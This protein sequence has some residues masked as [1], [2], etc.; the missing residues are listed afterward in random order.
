[1][2]IIF[3]VINSFFENVGVLIGRTTRNGVTGIPF[4]APTTGTHLGSE[5]HIGESKYEY[6]IDAGTT[7]SL[8][9]S[10]VNSTMTPVIVTSTEATSTSNYTQPFMSKDE[11][12]MLSNQ[13]ISGTESIDLTTMNEEKI[14]AELDN[15]EN[16][17]KKEDKFEENENEWKSTETYIEYE[18]STLNG[19]DEFTTQTA[20][21][22]LSQNS[23]SKLRFNETLIDLLKF[24]LSPL[25]QRRP[26][27]E[28]ILHDFNDKHPHFLRTI[29]SEITNGTASTETLLI[30]PYTEFLSLN[31]TLA[32]S[33][34]MVTEPYEWIDTLFKPSEAEQNDSS[35][36]FSE[37]NVQQ[38]KIQPRSDEE[39]L[40][41]EN[42]T[43]L[44][45]EGD[46]LLNIK[47]IH[48]N[49]SQFTLTTD[50]STNRKYDDNDNDNLDIRLAEE[51]LFQPSNRMKND[52]GSN[53][54]FNL[55]KPSQIDERVLNNT[56]FIAE[57]SM[58]NYVATE[59]PQDYDAI[60][61]NTQTE[62][63]I[64]PKS[65]TEQSMSIYSTFINRLKTQ[66][67]VNQNKDRSIPQTVKQFETNTSNGP[68]IEPRETL[69]IKQPPKQGKSMLSTVT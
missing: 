54:V 11:N 18:T 19:N 34:Q 65:N 68:T 23:V 41:L 51:S 55:I 44:E 58:R 46:Q 33:S 64:E 53:R 15:I 10:T 13:Y 29:H 24:S 27:I 21:E 22:P 57:H 42:A 3:R 12:T 69:I 67:S 20:T 66:S 4:I 31:D 43:I 37:E 47:L 26:E 6:S 63:S 62:Y 9:T 56:D 49:Q 59:E 8:F 40:S 28:D 32:I 38:S 16:E 7:S 60:E 36:I 25:S 52:I 1:M 48:E 45:S 50:S 39:L 30:N 2:I 35:E 14:T 61:G 5:D 17:T